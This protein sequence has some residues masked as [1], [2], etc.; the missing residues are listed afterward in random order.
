MDTL[1]SVQRFL[2]D[3][4]GTIYLGEELI[5]G[6]DAFVAYLRASGRSLLFFTNNPSANAVAYA[7]KL[8]RL[9]IA[10][11]ADEVL[12]AGAAT[13]RF[14]LDETPY[15]R[16]YTIA[17]PSLEAE[18][19]ASGLEPGA[20]DPEAVVVS[21]DTAVTYE[22]LRRGAELLRAG[23]PY[24]GTNPDKVCPTAMGPIPDTGSIAAFLEA[25]TGQTP[26][27][28]GKPHPEMVRMGLARL[29]AS[30][31]ETAMVGDRLYTDMAMAQASGV[32]GIL[33][34]SGETTAEDVAALDEPPPFVFASVAELH[35]ALLE[36]DA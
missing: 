25:A 30:P 13:I 31:R 20:E 9:G 32:T 7:A 26:K 3:M 35:A 33:V 34:L 4:D 17:P 6:A 18:M 36:A 5:P 24:I 15:R 28:I 8:S 21:F 22:K 11:E 2:L 23:L 12:T 27:Y 29:G 14:L 16:L 10:A 19:R 1:R